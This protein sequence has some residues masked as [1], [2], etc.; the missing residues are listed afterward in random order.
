MLP[1]N[2]KLCLITLLSLLLACVNLVAFNLIKEIHGCAVRNSIHLHHQ[3][4][5]ALIEVFERCGSLRCASLVFEKMRDE[6]KDVVMWSNL[7][8]TCT[9]HGEAEVGLE[10]FRWMETVEVR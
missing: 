2:L 3:L 5:S 8:P 6:D 4:S 1:L 7:I 9:F 10:S